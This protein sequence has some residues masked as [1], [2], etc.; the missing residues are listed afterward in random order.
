[1]SQNLQNDS[2]GQDEKPNTHD[3][4]NLLEAAGI[5]SGS[6]NQKTTDQKNMEQV[7]RSRLRNVKELALENLPL[8]EQD[9]DSLTLETLQYQTASLSIDIL[10]RLSVD[11]QKGQN[12]DLSLSQ[13]GLLKT[14]V[15]ILFRWKVTSDTERFN[16]Y[17]KS[18]RSEALK[19]VLK[20]TMR[21][22]RI[23]FPDDKEDQA[24]QTPNRIGTI[25]LHNSIP[26]ILPA[27]F[28]LGWLPPGECTEG[29]YIRASTLRIL[30]SFT[31]T[32]SM[33][34]LGATLG[35][36][37]LPRTAKNAIQYLLS[38]REY[39]GNVVPQMLDILQSE[40]TGTTS[41]RA[42]SFVL[43][44]LMTSKTIGKLVTSI[45]TKALYS[46]FQEKKDPATDSETPSPYSP[47]EAI[48]I[49]SNFLATAPPSGDVPLASDLLHPIVEKLYS[50]LFYFENKAMSDPTEV[51]TCRGLLLSW[52]KVALAA[53][54]SDKLW[55]IVQGAGGEWK[56][57]AVGEEGEMRLLWNQEVVLETPQLGDLSNLEKDAMDFNLLHLRPDPIHLVGLVKTI[58]R[59]E[60]A[61]LFFIRLLSAEHDDLLSEVDPTRKLLRMQI[62]YQLQKQLP[63]SILSN[64]EHAIA[65]VDHALTST[66]Q[67][68][69]S[70]SSET[71]LASLRF[72]NPEEGE[73]TSEDDTLRT[74]VDFLLSILE[75]N[76]KY[77]PSP[78]DPR[79]SR[80]SEA[81]KALS[82]HSSMALRQGA[83]EA[84]LVLMARQSGANLSNTE[85]IDAGV[86]SSREVYQEA[87][88]LL[89]DP[90]LP[91]RAQGLAMLR[92]LVEP[93]L[94]SSSTS[95]ATPAIP[96]IEAAL[97]PGILDIFIHSVQNEDSFIFLNA[98][99]GLAAMVQR[100]G[101][102]VF[103]RLLDVYATDPRQSTVPL[104]RQELD[105]KLRVGEALGVVIGKCGESLSGYVDL[106]VPVI[107]AIIRDH[108]L[109]IPLRTSAISL[110]S[111]CVDVAP[112][113][114]GVYT[115]EL[116]GSML[117]I[118]ELE[119]VAVDKKVESGTGSEGQGD[120]NRT[121]PGEQV[122]VD[123]DTGVI[124]P[125]RSNNN[126]LPLP[127]QAGDLATDANPTGIDPKVSPLRRSAVHLLTS[128]IRQQAA[129]TS[130]VSS[131]HV[132]R[133]REDFPARR[134]GTILRYLA[135][136]DADSMV[137][138]MAGE[139][140]V[141]LAR[142]GRARLGL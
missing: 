105:V 72:I 85:S 129:S 130:D 110:A 80:I 58:N 131:Y 88:V 24:S 120:L 26:E 29:A 23:I 61:S 67:K 112:L 69:T 37:G 22:L 6:A 16:S 34:M 25:L 99:Q 83:R 132:T 55:S 103:K 38:R 124:P 95:K 41:Q 126:L 122:G 5:L 101:R 89:Q 139:A 113:A 65:F 66:Q 100:F 2:I 118:L 50:L 96:P 70:I 74:A 115:A 116:S 90:L 7:L 136:V 43:S 27:V 49:L 54:V 104:S 81:L 3:P 32:E 135:S 64:P 140:V 84:S 63:S 60:V 40:G 102:E 9:L 52:M 56:M 46:G 13:Q 4:R 106:T 11:E 128:I 36:P 35:T 108:H 33:Q 93:P 134:A 137:N 82:M 47:S 59:K 8:T 57:D 92:H 17:T 44:N 1:M 31:L 51:S 127:F 76:P 77:V 39:L 98:V 20:T 133:A 87:L 125:K 30:N 114:M 117:D 142:V 111:R 73:D 79:V 141:L 119:H 42:V 12:L 78:N 97:V 28:S 14:L 91:V 48:T 94:S 19:K 10:E 75:A 121:S 45:T 107:L 18:E 53:D 21:L 86:K 62:I 15:A 109:P 71:P 68:S 138:E 123:G